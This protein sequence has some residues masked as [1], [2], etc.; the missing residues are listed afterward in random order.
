M[1]EAAISSQA[2]SQ[3]PGA[4]SGLSGDIADGATKTQASEFDGILDEKL[5][6]SNNTNEKYQSG[7][8]SLTDLNTLLNVNPI[9]T[10]TNTTQANNA[11]TSG[12]LLPLNLRQ[13]DNN[14]LRLPAIPLEGEYKASVGL[15]NTSGQQKFSPELSLKSGMASQDDLL[16]AQ[17]SSL[18]NEKTIPNIKQ[19]NNQLL[20]QFMAQAASQQQP[21]V[22]NSVLT[23]AA[24]GII[25]NQSL[26]VNSSEAIL[27][28]M[29]VSPSNPQWNAQ[30]GERINWMVNNNMQRADIRLDP[31]ELGNLDIRLQ[32]AKDNQA[33]ILVHVTNASAKEAIE[34]A[35]P[36]LKE[37]FEQQGLDLANVDVSQQDSSQQH[38]SFENDNN[39]DDNV[40]TAD[41]VGNTMQDAEQVDILA[42]T[43]VSSQ[44]NSYLIDAFA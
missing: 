15:L 6:S 16:L 9:L 40:L 21:S 32:V 37:M 7:M 27:P 10:T 28:A 36:R 42:T 17:T 44:G 20:N 23:G 39:N 8:Q 24:P 2:L 30:L 22:E 14:A 18:F 4:Q 19:L 41:S 1:S 29:T 38:S 11:E 26:S 35:I 13:L 43:N 33:T 12:N 34:S 25:V 31:P 3:S 5:A